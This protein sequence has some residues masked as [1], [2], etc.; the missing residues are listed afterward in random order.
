MRL[1][2]TLD[3]QKTATSS[4]DFLSFFF[5]MKMSPLKSVVFGVF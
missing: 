5:L 3:A 2:L 4:P 1:I